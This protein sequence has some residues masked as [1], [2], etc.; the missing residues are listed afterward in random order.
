VRDVARLLCDRWSGLDR[1]TALRAVKAAASHGRGIAIVERVVRSLPVGA[2]S[3]ED[4][5]RRLVALVEAEHKRAIVEE[6]EAL[7]ASRLPARLG[8]PLLAW[9]RDRGLQARGRASAMEEV[10]EL[11]TTGKVTEEGLLA[12][13]PQVPRHLREWHALRHLLRQ[14]ESPKR[15]LRRHDQP[16]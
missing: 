1:D 11:L 9:L 4:P 7:A 15:A 3:P 8:E 2:P 6:R 12:A 16:W 14:A 10:A 13:L 5:V